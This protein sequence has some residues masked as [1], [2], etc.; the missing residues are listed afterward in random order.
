MLVELGANAAGLNLRAVSLGESDEY[1]ILRFIVSDATKAK[2]VLVPADAGR[3]R[4]SSSR[5]DVR[6][7]VA[8]PKF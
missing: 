6:L 7:L 8:T 1:G 4:L 5:G 2:A 3:W